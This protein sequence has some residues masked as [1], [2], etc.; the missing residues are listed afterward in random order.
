MWYTD[1]HSAYEYAEPETTQIH[2]PRN[3]AETLET[4]TSPTLARPGYKNVKMFNYRNDRY[5][6]LELHPWGKHRQTP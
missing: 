5:W 6:A 3:M 2:D 4:L 1:I